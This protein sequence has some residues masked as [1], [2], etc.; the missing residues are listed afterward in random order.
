MSAGPLASPPLQ[1]GGN[2]ISSFIKRN[3]LLVGAGAVGGGVLLL[4]NRGSGE[5]DGQIIDSEG[6]EGFVSDGPVQLV[7]VA[8]APSEG[9]D[10]FDIEPNDD[11]PISDEIVEPE[12]GT[13]VIVNV[14]ANTT[15]AGAPVNPP[16]S[17]GSGVTING[18][19]FAGAKSHRIVGTQRAGGDTYQ[20]HLIDFPGRNEYWWFY[21][22]GPNRGRWTGPHRSPG[23]GPRKPD[24]PKTP[25]P[26]TKPPTSGP[27]LYAGHPLSYWQNPDKSRKKGKWQWP[28]QPGKFNHS[29][30]YK[31]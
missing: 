29:R 12:P 16:K 10:D 19:F 15:G 3:K 14:P 22:G 21:T 4:S 28:S 5:S 30:A 23:S 8:G 26:V 18:R 27:K 9:S 11:Q 6:N 31:K 17:A 25:A 24:G 7:P 2:K 13:T 20:I 1:R